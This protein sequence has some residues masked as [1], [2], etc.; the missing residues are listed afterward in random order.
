MATLQ[1]NLATASTR[2]APRRWY[3]LGGE[4]RLAW[5]LVSPRIIGF[6]AFQLGPMLASL[7]HSLTEW[8]MFTP[9]KFIGWPAT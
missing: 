8:R 1:G 4:E 9:P 2:N 7:G 5:L 3:Q 6:V